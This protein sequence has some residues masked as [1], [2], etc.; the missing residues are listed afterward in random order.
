MVCGFPPHKEWRRNRSV[1]TTILLQHKP[2]EL[3]N[4]PTVFLLFYEQSHILPKSDKTGSMKQN[5][6]KIYVKLPPQRWADTD[7]NPA[8]FFQLF[9]C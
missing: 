6:R 5:L 1:N 4:I 9:A 7:V 8:L 2:L 3:R